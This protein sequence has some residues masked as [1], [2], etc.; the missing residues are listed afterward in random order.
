MAV[1]GNEV[2]PERRRSTV[3]RVSA[4]IAVVISLVLAIVIY[5]ES[6]ILPARIADYVNRHYLA[7]TPFEFSLDGVSGTLVRRINLKNPTL[8]YNSEEA[9]YNVFRA[10]RISVTY[11]LV[12]V[13]AFRLLVDDVEL[14]NV[15]IHLRQDKE[16]RLILPG[17]GVPKPG[18][19][20]KKMVSPVVNVRRFRIDGL[21]MTFG[22]NE[23]ELAVRDVNLDGAFAYEGGVGKLTIDEGRAYLIDSKTTVQSVRINARSDWRSIFVDEFSVKLDSSFVMANGEFR[24]GRFQ[25]VN[26]VLKPISLEELHQLGLIPDEKGTFDARI[27]L[28]GTVDSLGVKGTAS[29]VGLGVELD[30][31]D[32]AGRVTPKALDLNRIEGRVFGAKADGTFYIEF[33]SEDFVYDGRVEDL[34]LGRGFIEDSELPPMS[35]YGDV[36]VEHTKAAGRYEWR[37]D[38]ERGVIDGYETFDV[39]AEGVWVDGVGLTLNRFSSTRPG[40]RVE[41]TGTVADGGPADIVFKVDGTDLTYF[42]EHFKLPPVRGAL[43]VNGRLEGPLD[44]FQ[45]NLNG[46]IRDLEWEFTKVDSGTVQAELRRVGT[47][48]PEVTVSLT[49]KRARV[50]DFP[51]ENPSLLMDV[52]TTSVRVHSVKVMRRDSTVTAD[53]DVFTKGKRS[54]IDL[55]RASVSTPNEQWDLAAPSVIYVN[56]D[57]VA[58]DSL[59]MTSP[60]GEFG[61]TG[62]RIVSAKQIDARVWGRNVNLAVFRDALKIPI[63][64]EGRSTFDLR[65]EGAEDNPRAR[66]EAEIKRGRVD[67]LVVDALRVDLAFDGDRYR[68]HDF[69]IQS[70][71]DTL[72]ATGEWAC[73]L[74]PKV[75]VRKNRPES[76]WRDPISVR[77]VV[78]QYDLADL[79]KAAHKDVDISSTFTGSFTVGGTLENP[80]LRT[81]GTFRPLRGEGLKIPPT[82][83]DAS[84]AKGALRIAKLDVSEVVDLHATAVVPMA[85]SFREGARIEADRPMEAR[86]EIKPFPGD[87]VSDF[88]PYLDRVSILRGIL[89]GTVDASGTPGSPRLTGGFSFT[90]GELRVK[91]VQESATEMSMRLDFVD[92]VVRLTSLNATSGK[93]GSLVGTGWARIS[94]YRPVDYE[95]NVTAREFPL[96]SIPDV[97]VTLGGTLKARLTEWRDGIKIPKLTGRIDVSEAIIRKELG[98]GGT[99]PAELALPSDRPDWLASIDIHAPKNVWFRND[100][101]NVEMSAD[102]L[103]FLRDERGMYF[104][105]ELDILRGSYKLYGNKFNITNGTMD[106][107]ASETL[108]PSMNIEAYTPHRGG[109]DTEHNIYLVLDWPYDRVEP[110]ISLSYDEPGYSESDIWTMLGGNIVYGG[111]ASNTLER[112]INQQF[113]GSEFTV[114]VDSRDTP[115]STAADPEQETLIGVGRYLWEDIYLQYRRGLS[116]GGEQEV[117]VEY[118]LGKKFLLRSQYIYNS[119]RNR[120]GIEGQNTDEFNLDLKYR[121]EY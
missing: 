65:L 38:L 62:S 34:D 26:L 39:S 93:K 76:L 24:E 84:Y 67:S 28:S 97:E 90:R 54:R 82:A 31:V 68:L 22:G 94:N 83:L 103:V 61:M 91:G 46:A 37:G 71:D 30:G 108:R 112:A 96:H 44:D 15:A 16:G 101:L 69:W 55:K 42:W 66:L 99:G 12:P 64:L 107:S 1:N 29:G 86:V 77:A 50:Y 23:T 8:R 115:G 2:R 6:Q 116:V 58:I 81:L 11:Q 45:V 111:V 74:P 43:A 79:F 9:S 85:I 109:E 98:E 7:G 27:S 120:A 78:S 60:R 41:G 70:G 13:F 19:Q 104:R 113:G 118:R 119:R 33:E 51:F 56:E 20:K 32:F 117:N 59:V 80:E 73:D 18:V 10:D 63:V 53:F 4:V 106:F 47:L 25:D 92:D 89:A 52:D 72:T 48:A 40:Y 75:L 100:D 49:G 121:F 114:D 88:A 57:E 36:H 102:E 14:E 105:G 3:R 35:L 95:F 5:H 21:E 17:T 110:H 87:A